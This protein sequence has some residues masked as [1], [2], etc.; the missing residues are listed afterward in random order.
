[1]VGSGI[2]GVI[3]QFSSIGVAM[4]VNAA[5]LMATAVGFGLVAAESGKAEPVVQQKQEK[6]R[7][8]SGGGDG[9]GGGRAST[10]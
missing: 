2:L 6:T 4:H 5:L 8:E 1:M 10:L 7:G 3:A 9:D